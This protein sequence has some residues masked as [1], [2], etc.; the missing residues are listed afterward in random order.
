M[1]RGPGARWRALVWG[2]QRRGVAC[3]N[4]ARR[5]TVCRFGDLHVPFPTSEHRCRSRAAAGQ[6]AQSPA[7]GARNQD[8]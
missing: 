6:V 2:I 4:E 3:L 5:G 8:G 7:E 1:S